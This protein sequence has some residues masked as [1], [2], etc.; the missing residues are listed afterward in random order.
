MS[1]SAHEGYF[2]RPETRFELG[3]CLGQSGATVTWLAD[4]HKLGRRVAVK[5][6]RE[7]SP[8]DQ[9]AVEGFLSAA[10]VCG[11]LSHPGI[12]AVHDFG[13]FADGRPFVVMAVVEGMTLS[14]AVKE[15][16]RTYT[17]LDPTVASGA[18]I[19]KLLLRFVEVCNALE[20][21]HS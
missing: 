3:R 19:R 13:I 14:E 2:V 1:L 18:T 7:G 5:T 21:A 12:V 8:C 4:D 6:L 9:E 15:Y 20:H 11:S 10:T 16:H 17:S